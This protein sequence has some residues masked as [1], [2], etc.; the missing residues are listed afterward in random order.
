MQGPG[1]LGL[2]RSE[3]PGLPL[4]ALVPIR[5]V[6]SLH[7]SHPS[8]PYTSRVI[9]RPTHS[10]VTTRSTSAKKNLRAAWLASIEQH[11]GALDEV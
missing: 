5:G 6:A 7:H 8:G 2:E 11:N 9:L 4:V 10:T 1:W 3:S